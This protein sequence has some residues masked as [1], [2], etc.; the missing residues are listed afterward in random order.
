MAASKKTADWY[1]VINRSQTV[2][3]YTPEQMHEYLNPPLRA[4][5]TRQER[6]LLKEFPKSVNGACPFS[7]YKNAK[8]DPIWPYGAV[9]IVKNGKEVFAPAPTKVKITA[10]VEQFEVEGYK[11]KKTSKK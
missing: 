1:V 11:P 5:G 8:G 7:G 3:Y 6:I 10:E 4:D 9:L 2:S